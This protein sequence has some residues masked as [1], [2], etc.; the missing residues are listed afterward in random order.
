MKT[1][2][3]RCR[4]P[5]AGR[6]RLSRPAD[7]PLHGLCLRARPRR[8]W[9]M[10]SASSTSTSPRPSTAFLA[11]FVVFVASILYLVRRERRWDSVAVASAEIGIVFCTLVLITGPLWAKPAWGT[12]WTWDP[13][14]TTT[15]VL[16]LIYVAYL[17]LRGAMEEPVA[18]RAGL[19]RVRHRR[20]RRRADRLHVDSLVAHHP[21][22]DRRG[23]RA[24]SDAADGRHAGRVHRRLSHSCTPI[25]SS[26]ACACSARRMSWSG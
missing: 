18:A 25:C 9:A 20:L 12:W 23:R 2:D 6:A 24:Q 17:M 5:P 1:T 22:G 7:R 11:F 19:G 4:R 8:R 26:S 10:C 3:L 16:W 21:P 15:M 14:L 13:R